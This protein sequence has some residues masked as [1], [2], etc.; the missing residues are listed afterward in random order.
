M[1]VY[2]A[3]AKLNLTLRVL[4]IRDDGFHELDSLMQSISLCDELE[5]QPSDRLELRCSRLE[6]ENEDNLVWKAAR[7]MSERVPGR[8]ARLELHKNIPL[9]AG[10]GGGS[11]DAATTLRALNR[12][13]EAGLPTAE[14]MRLGALL[15]SD[16]PFFLLGGLVRLRGRG[17]VLHPL[18]DRAHQFVAILEVPRALPTGQVYAEADRLGRPGSRGNDLEPAAFSL[19]PELAEFRQRFVEAG[20]RDVRL[21]GSGPT[22]FS[23]CRDRVAAE[24]LKASCQAQGLSCHVAV[25]LSREEALAIA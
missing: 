12:I 25:T 5:V 7:L 8:G 4:G 22:L 20:A 9:A 2:H 1:P 23:I 6:L 16:V 13:W 24:N 21:T 14:L 17:E 11:S 18:P 19:C 3:F 10:M 15:G